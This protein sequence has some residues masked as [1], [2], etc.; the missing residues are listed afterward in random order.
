[1]ILIVDNRDSFVWNLAEY[2]SLFDRV[3]VVPNTIELKEIRKIDPDGIVI[4]P[5]PGSPKNK[6]DIGNCVEIILNTNVPL[7]GVCL[8]HQIIGYAFGGDVGKVK[9]YHGKRSLIRHDGK[10][11]FEGVRNP[12]EAGRY[13]SLAITT[14]PKCLEV[15]AVSNDGIVMG[16]RHKKE[17]IEGVQ[18]HPESVLTPQREGLKIIRNFLRICGR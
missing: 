14:I 16:L 8:G 12:I 13:H 4:S 9:P 5:G 15:S 7:L 2:F 17:P 10:T 1:M 11:I 6:R 3:K 18:F